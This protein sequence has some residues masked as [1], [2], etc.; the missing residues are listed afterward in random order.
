MSSVLCLD[1][2]LGGDNWKRDLYTGRPKLT[3]DVRDGNC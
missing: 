1:K 3:C 2:T